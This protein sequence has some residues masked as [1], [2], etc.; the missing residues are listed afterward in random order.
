VR[1]KT[2]KY[3]ESLFADGKEVFAED[4]EAFKLIASDH[5]DIL[6]SEIPIEIQVQLCDRVIGSFRELYSRY[7]HAAF[8]NSVEQ[9]LLAHLSTA[10]IPPTEESRGNVLREYFEQAITSG[11]RSLD[12]LL[13]ADRVFNIESSIYDDIAYLSYSIK[14]HDQTLL[15]AESFVTEITARVEKAYEPPNLFLCHASE[16]KPFVERLVRELDKRAL[17]AWYDKR[18]IFVGDSIVEKVNDGLKS[19]DFLIA[20]LSRRSVIKPWVVHEMSSTLMRQLNDK[21]VHILPL[22]L[23]TCDIPPLFVDLKYADF[24]TSFD[25]G[26]RELI[27]AIR[28][29]KAT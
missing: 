16:D 9:G 23:E 25:S 15:E 14:I 18:E 10:F 8:T 5:G 19:C 13:E 22:V 29:S 2:D 3:C 28:H 27:A 11:A 12:P 26:V 6:L 7:P 21:G 24:R 17:F 4:G 20:V 1:L